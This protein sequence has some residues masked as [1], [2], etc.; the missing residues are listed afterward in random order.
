MPKGLWVAA[1]SAGVV[2]E[3]RDLPVLYTTLRQLGIRLDDVTIA[4]IPVQVLQ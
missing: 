3:T 4:F 1:N 2:A